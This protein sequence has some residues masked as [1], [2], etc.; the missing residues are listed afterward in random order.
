MKNKKALIIIDMQKGS[1]TP[2]TP[3][4]D[5]AKVI[6]RINT[7]GEMFRSENLPVIFVQHDGTGT[8]EFIPQT[9]EWEILNE[10]K[11]FPTDIL[12][13]KIANDVFYQSN[14]QKTLSNLK[15]NDLVITGCATDFCVE[16]SI[17]SALVKDFN[18]TIVSNGHTTAD[19]PHMNAE[20]IIKH[21]NWVWQNMTL[22]KGTIEVKSFERLK[23]ELN[24]LK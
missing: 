4:F 23:E 17:Q 22:T 16:S 1:F 12:M 6:Q 21:Y 18:I 19:R 7:L 11:V 9:T 5:S 20:N 24:S 15:V 13:T 10:L 2:D 14:F 8:N 3:R